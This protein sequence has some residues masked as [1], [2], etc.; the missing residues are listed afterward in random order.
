[1]SILA[2]VTPVP[3]MYHLALSIPGLTKNWQALL[4]WSARQAKQK[5]EVSH[6]E[7]ICMSELIAR[8]RHRPQSAMYVEID[9]GPCLY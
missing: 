3:W 2:T 5:M 8:L 1:M 9:R 6:V 4:S 7:S